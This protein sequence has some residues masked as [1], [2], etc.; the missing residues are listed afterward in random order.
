MYAPPEVSF[1]SIL[2]GGDKLWLEEDGRSCDGTMRD[3]G[4]MPH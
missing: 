2:G 1:G 4:G 3:A